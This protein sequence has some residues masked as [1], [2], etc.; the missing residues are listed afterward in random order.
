M[1]LCYYCS[2]YFNC[3]LKGKAHIAERHPGCTDKVY[4]C[5]ICYARFLDP[6][7]VKYH[8]MKH[9]IEIG[10]TTQKL[11]DYYMYIK[12]NPSVLTG[13]N[14]IDPFQAYR[15]ELGYDQGYSLRNAWMLEDFHGYVSSPKSN[16]VCK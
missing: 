5:D 10:S 4:S 1:W 11:N 16:Y 9:A 7:K 2:A 14:N 3:T 6:L 15:L 8:Q 12:K 13:S